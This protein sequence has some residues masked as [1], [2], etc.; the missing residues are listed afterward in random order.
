M[1]DSER[2]KLV[3][4]I[5]KDLLTLSPEELFQIATTVGP[6][7]GLDDSSFSSGDEEACFEHVTCYMQCRALLE[8]ED[9]GMA[10]LL[11]LR[12]VIDSV[13][14]GQGSGLQTHLSGDAVPSMLSFNKHGDVS[15][16]ESNTGHPAATT[17][18]TEMQE[19]MASYEELSQKIRQYIPTQTLRPTPPSPVNSR[20]ILHTNRQTEHYTPMSHDKMV[21][22]RELS[23]LQRREFKIQG[24]QIG[25]QGSDISYNNVCRQMEEGRREQFSEAEIVRAVLRAIKPGNFKDMLMNKDGLTVQE[26]KGFLHSHLGEQSSMELFQELMCTRQKDSE[27]PQQFLYRVI[28]LKQKILL[29]SKQADAG[30]KYNESTVRDVFLHTIYQGF[31]H[32]YDNIRGELKPLLADANVTDEA[33]L[34]QT[35]R[36]MRDENERHRRLGVATR[37]KP[38]GVQSAQVEANAAQSPIVKEENEEKK[39]K[40]GMIQ[41]LTEKVEKLTSLVE[42]MQQSVDKQKSE[43]VIRQ[44]RSNMDNKRDKPYGCD[45]CV[46]LNLPD[47]NH[48][49]YCGENGHRAVGCLQNPKHQG[50]DRRSLPG[51]RQ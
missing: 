6:V 38:T 30:V 8:S 4:S 35:N 29:A 10:H 21:S 7:P 19:I 36:T 27:T 18:D 28:G 31:T 34:K 32:R 40:M 47:C 42:L 12:D 17:N 13:I 25:D 46:Q 16:E 2:K 45:K 39:P 43:Q 23:Y 50:N 1:A 15:S 22:L 24:G 20:H 49:F 41:E 3:W 5:K 51:D 48:C 26:L 14:Q 9:R 37:Y 11:Q 33:I 44:R